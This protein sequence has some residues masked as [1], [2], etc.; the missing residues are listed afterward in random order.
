MVVI[1][2]VTQSGIADALG[3]QAGDVLHQVNGHEI[4]DV[5]DYRFYLTDTAIELNLSRN[6]TPYSARLSKGEYDDIGLEFETPLMDQKHTCANRCVFCFIDQLPKGMRKTLYFKD[7]DD[8]LSFLHGNYVTLTNLHDADIERLI[9]MHISPV[10]IS[11]HTTNPELRVKMMKNKRAGEVLSYLRKLADAGIALCT[12]IVLCKGFNDGL[13]LDRTMRDLASYFPAL[14]SCSIVPVGLT[15]YREGLCPLEGFSPAESAAVIAQVNAFG[16]E[17]LQKY[18]A[19]LFYCS[20]EF[21]IRAGLPLPDETFYEDFSQIENGVG[22]L[23]S[24]RG[25]FDFELQFLQE[26]LADFHAPRRVSVVTGYAAY[27]HINGLCRDLQ[28]RV[29]GLDIRVYRIRNDFFGESVTV[30]GLLTGQ[31]VAAQL[32]GEDLGDELLF[33]A[34]MLR[35]DGDVF[36]DDMTPEQLSERLGGIPVRATESDGAVFLRTLLGIYE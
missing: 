4:R 11:V 28:E 9:T 16:E 1:K 35:A 18:G 34:V 10:N 30:A 21:Y 23:S 36:L 3:I 27:D 29:N 22:M 19:R 33:P 13:E 2:Q 15:K 17:C 31:D 20:D 12:Q 24:M 8:R 32:A 5:L 26:T 7:D 14:R 25:E 6:G